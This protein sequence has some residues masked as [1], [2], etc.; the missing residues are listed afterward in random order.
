MTQITMAQAMTH[1]TTMIQ[2]RIL[3]SDWTQEEL[4]EGG[5][6]AGAGGFTWGFGGGGGGWWRG[7]GGFP[8]TVVCD[9]WGGLP[10]PGWPAWLAGI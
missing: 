8:E 6:G 10:W 4:P 3:K 5:F 9:V 7:A 2:Y 1:R